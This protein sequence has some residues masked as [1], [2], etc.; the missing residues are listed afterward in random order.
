M[1][2][3]CRF[4]GSGRGGAVTTLPCPTSGQT[5]VLDGTPKLRQQCIEIDWFSNVVEGSQFH[6]IDGG[7]AVA[8]GSHYDHGGIGTSF[9]RL[10]QPL[11]AVDARHS[12][13]QQGSVG[14]LLEQKGQSG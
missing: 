6:G 9:A 14:L 12:D 1:A 11:Q 13:I 4:S 3:H 7:G 10:A 8:V 5:T 2:D